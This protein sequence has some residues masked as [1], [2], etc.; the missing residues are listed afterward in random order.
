MDDFSKLTEE[1]LKAIRLRKPAPN[2]TTREVDTEIQRRL[3][4]K[5]LEQTATLISEIKTLKEITATNAE[6]SERNSRSSH[7]IAR[8]ALALA[9]ISTPNIG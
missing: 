4:D 8:F 3:Q 7:K 2:S 5:N 9:V 6:T 1:E